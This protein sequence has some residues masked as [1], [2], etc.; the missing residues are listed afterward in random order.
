MPSANEKTADVDEDAQ[1]PRPPQPP[2]TIHVY[3]P[4]HPIAKSK[5][6][7]VKN[8]CTNCRKACKK[9][10]DARPC[11]RCVK[12]GVSG[13][14]V[15][16]QR[17]PR[18][19]VKRGP[20]KRKE[21]GMFDYSTA[22][23]FRGLDLPPG[24][25]VNQNKQE[26]IQTGSAAIAVQPEPPH[27]EHSNVCGFCP[28]FGYPE[29][30]YNHLPPPASQAECVDICTPVTQPYFPAFVPGFQYLHPVQGSECHPSQVYYTY[31]FPSASYHPGQ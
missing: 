10:D 24:G 30:F 2:M 14:C 17:K 23:L 25:N 5:R 12:Y 4:S 3:S 15:D 8:A 31:A 19:R 22:I 13:D 18:K 1:S 27:A 6:R 7:Q 26:P 16:S 9:C 29:H 28:P 11:L 20:Y 21:K